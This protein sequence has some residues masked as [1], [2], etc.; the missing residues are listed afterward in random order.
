[1]ARGLFLALFVAFRLGLFASDKLSEEGQKYAQE[2]AQ[3]T[4]NVRPENRQRIGS[5]FRV[6]S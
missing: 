4:G 6:P 5:L 2:V 3:K 1:M